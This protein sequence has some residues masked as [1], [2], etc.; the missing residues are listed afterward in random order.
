MPRFPKTFGRRKSSSNALEAVQNEPEVE[1][2]PSSFKVFERH[3]PPHS[4]SF[5]AG[6]KLGRAAGMRHQTFPMEHED[7][8]FEDFKGS[9]GSG[10]SHTNTMSTADNSSRLSAAST[11][12][13]SMD[14]NPVGDYKSPLDKPYDNIPVPP[15]PKSSGFSLK[16]AGR[17]FSFGR[18][19]P[20]PPSVLRDQEHSPVSPST[21]GSS[22]PVRGGRER[23]V[24]TSSYA[25]TATPGKFED[26]DL[27]GLNLGGDFGDMFSGLQKRKTTGLD[28]ET[29][30]AMAH[31]PEQPREVNAPRSYG[32]NRP[33]QLSRINTDKSEPVEPPQHSW[34]SYHSNERLMSTPPPSGP[35]P[36]I[37]R[38][39]ISNG[40]PNALRPGSGIG[41]GLRKISTPPRDS[42]PEETVDEDARMIR[43][44]VVASRRMQEPP[45]VTVEDSYQQ[46]LMYDETIAN[47]A[48]L[49]ER[50][51]EQAEN[52]PSRDSVA[53]RAM[54]AAQFERYKEDRE[55]MRILGDRQSDDEDEEDNYEDEEDDAEKKK[56]LAKQRRKQEAHMAVYRQQMMK[57]TGET[58]PLPLR[59]GTNGS[60]SSPNL[61]T[62]GTSATP[63]SA[64]AAAGADDEEEDEE[65]PLAILAA[66][67]FPNKNKPPMANRASNPNLRASMMSG[68]GQA[69]GPLPVF[70]RKLPEDPYFGASVVNPSY[71]ESLSFGGGSPG[72]VHGGMP[73]GPS[74][75]GS[76]WGVPPGG[77][78]GV[79]A[80]E[81][82][83]R[84]MRRGSPNPQV[85]FTPPQQVGF[86]GLLGGTAR[87]STPPSMYN[88]M[89]PPNPM[90][91]TPGDQAQIA[92]TQQMQQFMTMQLQFMQM[93]AN[94]GQGGAAPNA[95][96]APPPQPPS[97]YQRP[98]SQN[99]SLRQTRA[100]TM[101]DSSLGSNW[102]QAGFAPSIHNGNTGGGYAPSIAPSERSN[103]GLPGRYRPVSQAPPPPVENKS[104][105]AS[106]MSGALA[107]W[108]KHGPVTSKLAIKQVSASDD[109]D[110]DKAW[111]EMAKKRE[112]KKSIWKKNKDNNGLREM[113]NFAT[114][115]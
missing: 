2:S 102:L 21:D 81:E 114:A 44:S 99:M 43:E 53:A 68:I 60:Q 36:A 25:S 48:V 42:P 88:G 110:E 1:S 13:S 92:M 22:S 95:P 41:P 45:T 19:K 83:S 74:P 82:R 12:P 96:M 59:P 80:G 100:M 108:E 91:L 49:A 70:A 50:F 52:P 111:E 61:T 107:N 101:M 26:V 104:Y 40:I 47:A 73:G 86:T 20:P 9:R 14:A 71:R 76:P 62:L 8:M 39:E 63:P 51:Q 57:V 17:T 90:L 106:T 4:H 56:E 105:R 32:F 37:P 89:V 18:Q 38:K 54:T 58:N 97:E 87:N 67:G 29:N 65:I 85:E 27:G 23:A 103:I 24:T 30:R 7:N 98:G 78:V 10:A 69:P 6:V 5:D 15:V 75:A 64:A 28:A 33:N 113:L 34:T 35:P 72:S 11:A 94:N 109:E 3:Q 115:E 77:L 93:M 112:K 31:S 84:A 79:I 46:D 55:R 66:H 16:N